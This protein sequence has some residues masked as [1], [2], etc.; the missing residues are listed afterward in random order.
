MYRYDTLVKR[1]HKDGCMYKAGA[2]AVWWGAV[3]TGVVRAD[4]WAS[5][6]TALLSLTSTNTTSKLM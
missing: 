1:R 3:V 5:P 6:H 4:S 2:V